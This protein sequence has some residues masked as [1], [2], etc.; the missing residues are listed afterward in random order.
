MEEI[1][2]NDKE[3]NNED[4]NYNY[5]ISE[6]LRGLISD[7]PFGISVT[8]DDLFHWTCYVTGP[9]DSAY[10]GITYEVGIDF[11]VAYPFKPPVV[12][13][14]T[15]IF[16]PNI[17]PE[18]LVD[19]TGLNSMWTPVIRMEHILVSLQGMM[20]IP[21]ENNDDINNYEAFNLYCNNYNEFKNRITQY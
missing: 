4:N 17:T 11:P 20:S 18:G 8:Y 6:E 3:N 7:P 2:I 15:P 10:E 13:F 14:I 5:R 9:N 16:H 12:L 21:D 1:P 19:I